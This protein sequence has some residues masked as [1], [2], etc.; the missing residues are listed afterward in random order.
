MKQRY[1]LYGWRRYPLRAA[2]RR[3]RTLPGLTLQE[4][5]SSYLGVYYD[6]V[7]DAVEEFILQSNVKDDEGYQQEPEFPEHHT[8]IYVTWATEQRGALLEGIPDLDLLT[9]DVL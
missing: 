2:A 8:L 1:E 9:T 3:L 5:E 6:G 7:A 4:R